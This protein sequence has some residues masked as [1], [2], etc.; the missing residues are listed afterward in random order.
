MTAQD[1]QQR[2]DIAGHGG[3]DGGGEDRLVLSADTEAQLLGEVVP[4]QQFDGFGET[5]LRIQRIAAAPSETKR[6]RSAS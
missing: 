2:L 3:P 6:M 1:G 5:A 4:V